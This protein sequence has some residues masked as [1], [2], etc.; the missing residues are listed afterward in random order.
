[1][2]SCVNSFKKNQKWRRV[3]VVSPDD[4]IPGK[5]GISTRFIS[6]GLLFSDAKVKCLD[7]QKRTFVTSDS[8]VI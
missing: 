8:L 3:K 7:V 2:R 4:L 6:H 1:M 5:E